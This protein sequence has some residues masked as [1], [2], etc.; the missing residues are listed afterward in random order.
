MSTERE[1]GALEARVGVLEEEVKGL[2][3]D[4]RE[5]LAILNAGK[6]SWRTLVTVGTIATGLGAGVATVVSWFR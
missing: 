2:R 3:E 5:L 4:V 6:G 1:I